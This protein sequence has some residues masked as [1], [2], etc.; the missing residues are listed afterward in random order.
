MQGWS[1]TFLRGARQLERAARAVAR[2]K[3]M[4]VAPRGCLASFSVNAREAHALDVRTSLDAHDGPDQPSKHEQTRPPSRASQLPWPLQKSGQPARTPLANTVSNATSMST[5]DGGECRSPA[6]GRRA[7][8]VGRCAVRM[9]AWRPVPGKPDRRSGS[10]VSSCAAG[11]A[12]LALLS[13]MPMGG[14][15][16][17]LGERLRARC[18]SDD[19][20]PRLPAALAGARARALRSE[21]SGVRIPTRCGGC[22]ALSPFASAARHVGTDAILD[23]APGLLLLA[24]SASLSV[25]PGR[26]EATGRLLTCS[27]TPRGLGRLA[28]SES[29]EPLRHQ[30]AHG[31][32]K[33]TMAASSFEPTDGPAEQVPNPSRA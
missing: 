25:C 9:L 19:A 31:P 1:H 20:A 8:R 18:E 28:H 29:S 23:A 32:G 2:G 17:V 15:S 33:R 5:N 27:R 10:R 30:V 6:R 21:S 16:C 12:R 14:Q 24:L 3:A 13:S 7:E 22:C 11:D 26:C 4:P